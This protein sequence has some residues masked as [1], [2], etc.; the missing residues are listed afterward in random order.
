MIKTWSSCLC[1]QRE[2]VDF[3]LSPIC[4]QLK[5][6]NSDGKKYDTDCVDTKNALH[7]EAGGITYELLVELRGFEPLAF[8]MPWKRSNQLSYNPK[9]DSPWRG[10]LSSIFCLR[11]LTCT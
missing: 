7:L 2:F 5:L 9:F 10:E 6:E 4:L 1:N 11:I 3:Q 8:S